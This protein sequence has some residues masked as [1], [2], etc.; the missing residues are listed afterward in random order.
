MRPPSPVVAAQRM[1]D[2]EDLL[3]DI[4][5]LGFAHAEAPERVPH[6]AEVRIED[7]RELRRARHAEAD[8]G[9]APRR[10]A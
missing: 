1:H 8:A 4:G 5:S 2:D 10:A 6:P 9:A 7:D 3:R